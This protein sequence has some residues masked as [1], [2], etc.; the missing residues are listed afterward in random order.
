MTTQDL[1]TLLYDGIDGYALSSAGRER[2]ASYSENFT[3]GEVTPEVTANM[4]SAA[5]AQPGE[6]FYDLGAGTGKG[7]LYAA[8][9]SD[10]G[11]CVGIELI[12]ELHGAAQNALARYNAEVRPVLP[13]HKQ[14]QD[15]RFICGDMLAHDFSDGDIV[16][17]H[18]TCFSPDLMQQITRLCEGL[19]AGSRVIT[20]SKGLESPHFQLVLT[21]PCQM[22]WG[23]ATLYYYQRS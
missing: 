3:Y 10:L 4:L 21:Q 12:D 15:I 20:V 22:A 14:D 8:F 18:C 19:K 1:Q 2:Y 16:F 11:K 5:N 9:M 6:V 23:S 17:M 7:V 13:A